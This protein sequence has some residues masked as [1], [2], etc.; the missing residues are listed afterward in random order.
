MTNFDLEKVW[1]DK[2]N[3]KHYLAQG[4]GG[5]VGGIIGGF[6][7]MMIGMSIGGYLFKPNEPKR[8]FK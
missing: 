4:V 2:G 7:G 6:P 1:K 5:A 3:R 8:L